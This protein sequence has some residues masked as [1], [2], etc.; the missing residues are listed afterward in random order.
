MRQLDPNT[1]HCTIRVNNLG[2]PVPAHKGLTFVLNSQMVR[3]CIWHLTGSPRAVQTL[4]YGTTVFSVLPPDTHICVIYRFESSNKEQ[5]PLNCQTCRRKANAALPPVP[6]LQ[7][8]WEG[9]LSPPWERDQGLPKTD[10]RRGVGGP[11]ASPAPTQPQTSLGRG[12]T[13]LG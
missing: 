1:S 9:M 12:K 11:Q 8:S 3:S 4:A 2:L 6:S 7:Q 10:G 13:V 5:Q